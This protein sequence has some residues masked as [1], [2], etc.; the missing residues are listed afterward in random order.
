MEFKRGPGMGMRANEGTVRLG[1]LKKKRRR[2]HR[3]FA[4]FSW[5]VICKLTELKHLVVSLTRGFFNTN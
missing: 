5:A 1:V 2:L 3:E 4:A